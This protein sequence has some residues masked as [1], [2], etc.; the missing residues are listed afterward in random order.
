M[1]NHTN[2][3][4]LIS[5]L[6]IGI[7]AVLIVASMTILYYSGEKQ[8]DP[9]LV[10]KVQDEYSV[11]IEVKIMQTTRGN[12]AYI[13]PGKIKWD[14]RHEKLLYDL[15]NPKEAALAIIEALANRDA[16]ALDILTSRN[17]KDNWIAQGYNSTSMLEVYRSDMKNI[18]EPYIIELETGEND[19]TEGRLSIRIIRESDE[20]NLEL[21]KQIDGTWKL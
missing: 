3:I 11:P 2:K 18:D 16:L 21:Y 17:T 8:I 6:V 10:R 19:P 14:N 20:M 9:G 15:S 1:V 12:I 5:A 13:V 7:F 4:L